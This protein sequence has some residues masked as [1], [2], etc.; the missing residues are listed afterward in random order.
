MPRPYTLWNADSRTRWQ[1]V[2][3]SP[4]LKPFYIIAAPVS[5][6]PRFLRRR[7][8]EICLALRPHTV[9]ESIELTI[10]HPTRHLSACTRTRKW[11]KIAPRNTTTQRANR[12]AARDVLLDRQARID[13]KH[14]GETAGNDKFMRTICETC[15]FVSRFRNFRTAEERSELPKHETEHRRLSH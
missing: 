13:R 3:S 2:R 4:R 14:I 5:F 8:G 15:R 11:D 7:S 6:R 12:H 9:S 10:T 1:I